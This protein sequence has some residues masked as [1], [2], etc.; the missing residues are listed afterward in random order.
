MQ[1]NGSRIMA[2]Y[3]QNF[4]AWIGLILMAAVTSLP[5]LMVGISSATI[6]QSADLA[7]G[8]ILG[9]CAFNL[10][11]LS[12]DIMGYFYDIRSVC[13]QYGFVVFFD[14]IKNLSSIIS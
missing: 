14:E 9:S 3:W 13:G 11:I 4:R 5:E 1:E 7:V 10:G 6:V 8:D 12:L 2:I